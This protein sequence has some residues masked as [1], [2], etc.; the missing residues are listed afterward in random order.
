MQFDFRIFQ[1]GWFNHQQEIFLGLNT[2]KFDVFLFC[3]VKKGG[4]GIN[5]LIYTPY[6]HTIYNYKY[7]THVL[8]GEPQKTSYK[9]G[10]GPNNSTKKGGEISP[11][12]NQI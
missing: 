6:I 12:G 4:M 3:R 11:Q 1:L 7:I 9:Q 10:R 5:G 8:Q 2:W